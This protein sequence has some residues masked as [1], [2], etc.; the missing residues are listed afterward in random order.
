MNYRNHFFPYI[1]LG[2]IA[3][4]GALPAD[5][6]P[7][8]RIEREPGVF[9]SKYLIKDTGDKIGVIGDYPTQEME[10]L[11]IGNASALDTLRKGIDY[12]KT[13]NLWYWGFYF[14]T[15]AAVT[16]PFYVRN[17]SE[18]AMGSFFGGVTLMIISGI[19]IVKSEA[20]SVYHFFRAINIYNGVKFDDKLGVQFRDSRYSQTEISYS[21][22]F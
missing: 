12:K 5:A 18:V 19:F 7:H 9:C 21:Y 16:W 10:P 13:A 20:A 4:I 14:G 15:A 11:F 2:I 17:Y 1:S 3:F 6:T 8:L 22:R